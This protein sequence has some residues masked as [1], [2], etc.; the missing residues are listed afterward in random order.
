MAIQ[1]IV[2][3]TTLRR[4]SGCWILDT[5]EIPNDTGYSILWRLAKDTGDW[6]EYWRKYRGRVDVEDRAV[7]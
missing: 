1:Y 2:M 3:V 6:S 4:C 7:G 5:V